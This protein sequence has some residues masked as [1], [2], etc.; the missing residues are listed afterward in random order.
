MEPG[1][2][3]VILYT[4]LEL[5]IRWIVCVNHFLQTPDDVKG[6]EWTALEGHNLTV[7]GVYSYS[8]RLMMEG[9]ECIREEFFKMRLVVSGYG[10]PDSVFSAS[11]VLANR[12]VRSKY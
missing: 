2:R 3:L 11:S 10:L 8:R 12:A 1:I 7:D 9:G 5:T 6:T 4:H